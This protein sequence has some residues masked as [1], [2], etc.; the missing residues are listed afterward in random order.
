MD[1]NSKIVWKNL[2]DINS[3]KVKSADL[4][5]RTDKVMRAGI[6]DGWQHYQRWISK[7][8]STKLDK[9]THNSDIYTWKGY[10]MWMDHVKRSWQDS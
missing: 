5:G 7:V 2:S 9:K 3:T 4:N 6:Q 10:R 1:N 8:P